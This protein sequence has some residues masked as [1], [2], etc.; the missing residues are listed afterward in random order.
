MTCTDPINADFDAEFFPTTGWEPW[1]KPKKRLL[2]RHLFS[3]DSCG[4]RLREVIAL[5]EGVRRG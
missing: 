1:R 4:A 3:C 2:R 5:A